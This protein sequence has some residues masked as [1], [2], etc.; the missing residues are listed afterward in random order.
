MLTSEET[1]NADL[2]TIGGDIR[3]AAQTILNNI[4]N[5]KSKT[6]FTK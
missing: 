3:D 6:T 5:Y 1:A 4:E 2:L